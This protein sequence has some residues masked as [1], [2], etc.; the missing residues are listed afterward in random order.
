MSQKLFIVGRKDLEPRAWEFIGVFDDEAKAVAACITDDHWVGPV[1]LN[2]NVE[3][4][5][6]WPGAWY[7]TLE[8]RPT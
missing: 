5:T 2:E 4:G 8:D 6:G 7:P 3:T 1:T